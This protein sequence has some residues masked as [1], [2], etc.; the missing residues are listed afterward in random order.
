MS[1]KTLLVLRRRVLCFHKLSCGRIKI[2]PSQWK[3]KA[4][5]LDKFLKE[6]KYFLSH[7]TNFQSCDDHLRNSRTNFSWFLLDHELF[8]YFRVYQMYSF[9]T[10]YLSFSNVKILPRRKFQ[11][12]ELFP[13]PIHNNLWS[14]KGSRMNNYWRQRSDLS[15]QRE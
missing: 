5:S 10:S 11:T 12:L 9:E 13:F 4:V 7:Q 2:F 3:S 6:N 15:F 8:C 1:L 14:S